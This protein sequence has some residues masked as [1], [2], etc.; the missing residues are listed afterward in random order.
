MKRILLLS[1]MFTFAFAFN[2]MAQRT[3]TGQITEAGGEPIPGVNVVLKGTSTG[4]TSDIDGTYRISVP[5]D[6]GILVFSFIGMAAQEVE[7]GSRSVIDVEMESDVKQLTEVVVTALGV[8]RDKKALGYSVQSVD[9][10]NVA[11]AAEPNVINALQGE[12]AGVQIQGTSGALGG[13][14][15]ITVRG[16]NSFLGENQPLFVVDG[17]PINNDNY[18]T[19]A[20]QSGFGSGA[21]DYG[22]AAS[23]IN[24]QDI[25]SMSVLKGA[26][27]T[28]LYGTRGANGV[29]LITTKSGAK[30]KGIGVDVS[31]SVTFEKAVNMIEHQQKY[32]GGATLSTPSGFTEFTENGTTYYAPVYSKDGAWGPKYEGQPVRHWD[33]WD[34]NSANYGETRPWSAPENG[35]QE[36]FETGV[37]LQNSVALSGGNDQGSFR[38]SYT[39]LD[40]SGI[41]PNSGLDRN[42]FSINARYNLS[43]KLTVTAAGSLVKQSALG[44]TATGYSNRN[45]MQGFTQWWQTQLDLDRMQNYEWEDG[46]HY[47]WNPTGITQN[48]DGSLKSWNPFPYFFDN[49]YWVRHKFLQ[50][51]TRDRFFGNVALNYELMDGLTISGRAMTDGFTFRAYEGIEN[52]GVDQ[53]DYT[54]RTR[55]FRESNFEGKIMYN[56]Q[57]SPAFS[58]NALI[59]GNLMSQEREYI[60]GSVNG[61]LAL[62][63]FFN[64]SNGIGNPT[65]TTETTRKSINSVF[66]SASFGFYSTVFVDLTVRGDW[67]ST[68][69]ED[70]NNYWYPSITSSFVFTELEALQNNDVLSFG[71]LRVGY[72]RAGNDADPYS[73]TNTFEPLQPNFGSSPRY[74]VPNARNNPNLKP[75]FTDEFEVGLE[76]NFF[77]NRVGFEVAYYDRTTT[78]QIFAVASSST[79]GFTSRIVN[80]GSMKNSGFEVMLRGTPVQTGDFSWDVNLNFA[81]Y[82][83]EVVELADGVNN[84]IMGS[85]WAA[86]VRLQKGDPYM[87]IYGQD[88]QRN[89][90]GRIIV[91]SDGMPL[92]EANRKYLGSAI[93]DFTGGLRNT[94]NYKGVSLS[95]LVDFQK[96]GSIHSTSLQWAAYSGMLPKTAEGNIREEGMI[97]D[98]VTEEGGENTVAVNPQVYYQTIWRVAAPNVYDASFVKLREMRLGYTLPNRLLGDF[99]I[100]DINVSLLGRNLMILYSELPFLDPQ[101]VTGTGN[102]Q[103]LENAQ[104]PST[105]SIGF[106][107]SF[108]L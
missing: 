69:P 28:A 100:R 50:E 79:T 89:E 88:F 68:L 81:T 72:G 58:L 21:Y 55:T 7:I 41:L 25:E 91:G 10:E 107:V 64:L 13:S 86:D 90:D 70:N 22:N 33:S 8:S 40:Q 71:K 62:D 11:K 24:P 31:S 76:M 15:R 46:T 20:Q 102:I 82:N 3:V 48:E 6:G 5:E 1:F 23:D 95:A 60:L 44:R 67:S 98:G 74:T 101:V 78:E 108:K 54:E 47:T 39:N 84:I 37:T 65:L 93:A 104:V 106:N 16:S 45:P 34:P 9:A 36:F 30:K 66:G 19:N 53:S 49:P 61:G 97:I 38:L 4:T 87:A 27:A 85:T 26:A 17:M 75:E 63:G 77:Q 14:S 42:T 96:G 32:G 18:A 12:I 57:F 103:G 59:G 51:D 99:P 52:G 29:I 92:I 73:L 2:A 43:D 80:A 94:F 56:K 35:Y 83:N 105:R